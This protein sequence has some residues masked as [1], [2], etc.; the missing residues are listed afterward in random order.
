MTRDENLLIV[1]MEECGELSQAVAKYL[2]FGPDAFHPNDEKKT[3]N[4]CQL[5]TEYHHIQA[6]MQMLIQR[7]ILKDFDE[8]TQKDIMNRKVANVLKYEMRSEQMGRIV[9]KE[10]PTKNNKDGALRE[11]TGDILTPP[12]DGQD[13]IICHQVN[14][15][16]VMGAGLAKQIKKTFPNVYQEYYA[17]CMRNSPESLLGQVQIVDICCFSNFSVANIFGQL[18]Y[19]RDRLYTDYAALRQA[20]RTLS[21]KH[22][23]AVIRIPYGMGCGLGGGNW[24]TVLDIIREELKDREIEI[25]KLPE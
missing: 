24:D 2:R 5:L 3:T 11:V 7:G 1:L 21:R 8:E 20:L 16:G 22:P 17:M 23:G 4:S 13:V 9:V 18:A 6:V 10:T 19:G 14:C 25:W 12:S 15:K